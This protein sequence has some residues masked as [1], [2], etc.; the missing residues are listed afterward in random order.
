MTGS[1]IIRGARPGS[2]WRGNPWRP[3]LNAGPHPAHILG[4][5]ERTHQREQGVPPTGEGGVLVYRDTERGRPHPFSSDAD[6]PKA[7]VRADGWFG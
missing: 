4:T 6:L 2:E 1:S 5:E 7:N 3:H